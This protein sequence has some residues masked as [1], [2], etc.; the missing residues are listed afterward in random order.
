LYESHDPSGRQRFFH[1]GIQKLFVAHGFASRFN[2]SP[3]TYGSRV[4][5]FRKVHVAI[6]LDV[7]GILEFYTL[8]P[9]ERVL[10]RVGFLKES[11][12][13]VCIRSFSL[14]E[15]NLFLFSFEYPRTHVSRDEDI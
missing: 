2:I 5:A 1:H 8:S 7:S 9:S 10:K 4:E 11:W 12:H 3:T 14:S 6:A 13:L 15:L